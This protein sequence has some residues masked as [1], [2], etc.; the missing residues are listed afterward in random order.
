MTFP[1]PHIGPLDPGDRKCG[2]PGAETAR[3]ASGKDGKRWS[4]AESR[5][6]RETQPQ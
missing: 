1:R 2:D 5:A 6:V 3:V 4:E